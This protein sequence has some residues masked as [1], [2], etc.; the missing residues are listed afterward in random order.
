MKVLWLSPVPS[1]YNEQL[2]GGWV[3]SLETIFRK[4]LP[5]TE[6]GICFES[7]DDVFKIK[8][9]EV[10]YYPIHAVRT[11]K[12]KKA[13]KYNYNKYWDLLHPY[14][15]KVIKDFEPDIIHCFGSEWP[16]GQVAKEIDIPVIIHMQGYINIYNMS[17]KMACSNYDLARFKHFNPKNL[18]G[19]KLQDRVEKQRATL[20]FDTMRHNHFFMGRTE[21]DKDIVKYYSPNSKYYYCPEAIRPA[22]YEASK[23]WEYQKH[24]N[25][26]I[27]SISAATVLKGNDIIL[28]AAK[29]MKDLG[30]KF[31]WRV[32]GHK[33]AF[34]FSESKLGLH[35]ENLNI[36]L[37]GYIDATQIVNELT[38]AD[39]YVHAAI[40]DNS[41]NSL[42]EAQLIGCPVI[43]TYAG[44]IPEMVFGGEAGILYPYNEPHTLAFK[45]M[46]LFHNPSRMQDLS[47]KEVE[48]SHKRHDPE[49][50]AKT[51]ISIYKEVINDYKTNVKD[52]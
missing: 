5:D 27:V 50:L 31:E 26:K 12:D 35:H 16:Y 21:W 45:L 43:T 25:M 7:T 23:R 17:A 49:Q 51:T 40:I 18:I 15:L 20:E 19:R 1:L 9:E 33:D 38:S 46:D 24:D 34:A 44:G 36:D 42:C 47:S 37:I 13:A 32:A 39:C 8:R 52:N 3:A 28:L 6:L 29:V 22:I 11:V 4:Y 48:L 30:F 10:T 2:A 41:P 14:I